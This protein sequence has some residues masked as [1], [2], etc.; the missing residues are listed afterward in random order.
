M[1]Q[2]IAGLL[3]LLSFA[4]CAAFAAGSATLSLNPS[5]TAARAG[6]MFDVR[7]SGNANGQSID[8]VRAVLTF[9]PTMV[10]AQS[11]RLTGGFDRTAPGNYLDNANGKVS[12]GAF[13]LDKP[14]NETFDYATVTFLALKEGSANMAVSADSRMVSNGEERIDVGQLK[15]VAY[16]IETAAPADPLAPTLVVTSTTQANDTDWYPNST[17]EMR[18][19]VNQA[20][21]T[22]KS[23]LVAFDESS[24]TDPKES[25]PASTE[26]RSYASVADGIHY[27]HI[28]GVLAQGGFTPT[29]HRAV[30]IDV[31]A[32]REF[33][34]TASDTK[35]LEGESVWLTFAT[36]DGA[37]GVNQYQ[38]A[39]NDSAYQV[40]E[41]PLEITDLKAGTYLF[42]V[43]ALDRAGNS[44]Y[45]SV[46][47]RV[48][49]SGTDLERPEGYGQAPE[50][51]NVYP[52]AL[53]N[54]NGE[55]ASATSP[56]MFVLLISL[57]L[58]GLVAFGIIY[59]KKFKKS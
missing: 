40:Q 54:P 12:W 6:E 45:G 59:V 22:I 48:Y 4:P 41:S 11:V 13:T 46:S 29:V 47:V 5:A 38:M 53:G 51:G 2:T 36:T 49:P 20:Q 24:N 15:S 25:L 1:K 21:K 7:I 55:K 28:K 33:L 19:S 42:R 10:R 35:I 31:D 18:W 14:V 34:V 17:V 27:F 9:D 43:A 58:V 50:A 56:K 23:F 44:K 30:K 16:R 32:P 52:D 57:V 26:T 37:S 8:T 39:I 3:V